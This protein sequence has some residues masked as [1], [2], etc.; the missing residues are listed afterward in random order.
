MTKPEEPGPPT[1]P[2]HGFALEQALREHCTQHDLDPGYVQFAMQH[3]RLPDDDWRWCCGSNCDPCVQVL[4]EV[5]DR[6]RTL[7]GLGPDGRAIE[8]A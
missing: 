3:L 6:A 2:L 8:K 7:A 5:V 4:G 1:P